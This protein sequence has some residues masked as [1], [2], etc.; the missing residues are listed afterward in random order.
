M[1]RRSTRFQSSTLVIVGPRSHAPVASHSIPVS[2]L[3]HQTALSLQGGAWTRLTSH[4]YREPNLYTPP[5]RSGGRSISRNNWTL[6]SRRQT[7]CEEKIQEP[8][9]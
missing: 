2:Q 8:N 5:Q 7:P 6:E 9:S 4:G 1:R 3:A